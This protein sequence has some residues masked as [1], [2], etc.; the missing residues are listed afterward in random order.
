MTD[1]LFR[2]VSQAEFIDI[3]ITG[4]FQ[5]CPNSVEGKYFAET[6]DDAIEWGSLLYKNNDFRI[7]AVELPTGEADKL[8]RW[9]S[10]DGIGPAR[11]AGLQDLRNAIIT[12]VK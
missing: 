1:F 8:Y 4:G 7:I 10:L 6:V 2:A 11:F 12:V 3:L 5:I 9:K